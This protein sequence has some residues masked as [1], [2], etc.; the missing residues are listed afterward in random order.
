MERK[1]QSAIFVKPSTSLPNML[2]CALVFLIC[3]GSGRPQQRGSAERPCARLARHM[4]GETLFLES[5]ERG[6]RVLPG[7]GSL[8]YRS[9]LM[10]KKIF[11]KF[12]KDSEL[13]WH[14]CCRGAVGGVFC[15]ATNQGL[16][17]S[18]CAKPRCPARHQYGLQTSGRHGNILR[19]L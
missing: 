4:E 15:D 5:F 8:P 16:S 9:I 10:L 2:R 14:G 1:F 12:L 17:K 7:G 13:V 3:T 6:A 11:R 19:E 18:S